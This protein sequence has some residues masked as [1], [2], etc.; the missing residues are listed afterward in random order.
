MYNNVKYITTCILKMHGY[1]VA[2]SPPMS[3]P[4]DKTA[5]RQRPR[6]GSAD[7]DILPSQTN[8]TGSA[9]T[10]NSKGA[11]TN[12]STETSVANGLAANNA[13]AARLNSSSKASHLRIPTGPSPPQG[14]GPQ[15]LPSPTTSNGNLSSE[16]ILSSG[17]LSSGEHPVGFLTAVNAW[18][19][20]TSTT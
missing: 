13:G 8:P 2:A 9:G 6:L 17:G 1:Q 12:T 16:E 3:P 10:S 4:P 15:S 14:A 18:T 7:F 11:T 20:Y 5:T 19:Y